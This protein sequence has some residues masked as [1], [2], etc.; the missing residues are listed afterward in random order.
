MCVEGL[1][2]RAVR[3]RRGLLDSFVGDEFVV[4]LGRKL[5]V[6]VLVVKKYGEAKKRRAVN[7]KLTDKVEN[8][9]SQLG[10]QGREVCLGEMSMQPHSESRTRGNAKER[11][12]AT[13]IR[14]RL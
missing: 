13:E 1:E 11:I 7:V 2:K 8:S 14:R 10:D 4:D 5:L 3:A 6:D 9:P 12:A